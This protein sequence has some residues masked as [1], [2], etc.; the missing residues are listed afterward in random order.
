MGYQVNARMVTIKGSIKE[1]YSY[2]TGFE[3]VIKAFSVLTLHYS[4][5]VRTLADGDVRQYCSRIS[6][7]TL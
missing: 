7:R 1:N 4:E 3:P 5:L 6:K 2:C